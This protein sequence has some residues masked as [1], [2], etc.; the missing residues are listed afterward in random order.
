MHNLCERHRPASLDQIVGQGLAVWQ[1]KAF[2]DAPY[3]AGWLF[4]GPTG[5]GK[6]SAAIALAGDLGIPV[7]DGAFGGH[8]RVNSGEQSADA[9]REVLR[10]ARMTPLIGSGW[11]MI[12]VE[13]ADRMA[14]EAVRNLWLSGLED[15]PP[16]TVVVMT[17]NHPDKIEQRLLDRLERLDFRSDGHQ[18]AQDGQALIDRVWKA[19][20]GRD[21]APTIASLPGVVRNGQISF[22]RVVAALEPML[23]SLPRLAP[24]PAPRPSRRDLTGKVLPPIGDRVAAPPVLAPDPHPDAVVDT[25]PF[26]LAPKANR[27]PARPLFDYDRTTNQFRRRQA[28]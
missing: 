3:S 19:E 10:I 13:E 18:L 4:S 25:R 9:V 26:A 20:T 7:I 1:L 21:D 8:F 27:P 22:R 16:R 2:V 23:R 5:T 24:A 6:T 28:V 14:S 15:L 11:R 17:T 12:Q